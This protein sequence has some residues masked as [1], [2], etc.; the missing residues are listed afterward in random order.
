MVEAE[1]GRISAEGHSRSNF[2]SGKGAMAIG[3]RQ[4]WWERGR[5]GGGKHG[6]HRIGVRQ[7]ALEG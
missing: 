1:G 5:V 7:D 4:A 3:I 2:G 6:H